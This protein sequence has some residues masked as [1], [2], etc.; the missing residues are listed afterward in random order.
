[1]LKANIRLPERKSSYL[2]APHYNVYTLNAKDVLVITGKLACVLLLCSYIFYDSWYPAAFLF[3]PV[4]CFFGKKEV[5]KLITQRKEK[6]KRE[7]LTEISLLNDFLRS[8]YSFEN[9]LRASEKELLELFGKESD[10]LKEIRLMCAGFALNRTAEESFLD[11]S[12]RADIPEIS[13]FASVFSLVNRSGGQIREVIRASSE[14]LTAA[15]SVEDE[16]RTM[17]ASKRMEQMIMDIMP[18]GILLYVRTASPDLLKI[19]YTTLTGN[20]IMTVC[21]AVYAGAYF[22]SEKIMDIHM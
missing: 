9:A 20:L 13:E 5:R 22:W 19:M 7:F 10:M 21:L 11:L 14:N 4:F 6:L 18:L 15:F 12:G 3:L 1:M 2:T 17:I 8:G 16:I